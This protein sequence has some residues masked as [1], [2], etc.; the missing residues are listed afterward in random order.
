[1]L[2]QGRVSH[3]GKPCKI[4]RQPVHSGDAIEIRE[5]PDP[6]VA[7]HGLEIVYEDGD[8]LV[9]QK[10]ASLLTVATEHERE[11][12]AYAYLRAY[13]RQEF[14]GRKLFIVHRLDKFV[15]GVMTFAKSEAVKDKL[16]AMF[17]KHSI[18]RRYWA[19]VEGRVAKD[20]GTIQSFLAEDRSR[21]MRSTVAVESG[22]HAITH[23][24]VLRRFPH[25]T[26]LEVSLE[27]GRKNQI[28]AH[29]SEMGHPIVGDKAY[30]STIDPFGRIALHAFRLGFV[31]P[32]KGKPL[33]FE[34][35]P[36]PELRKY[37]PHPL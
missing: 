34:T 10:P 16:Q 37:L 25:Y 18:E 20:T 30:G 1:M 23:Y 4:A 3:N 5:K 33:L 29:L 19:I 27:T 26:T 36:P 12:T 9:V 2:S 15:S 22:K 31:H 24:R 14:P 8:L 35:E 11:Q 17:H 21:R 13:L 32:T 28:R 6:T 7:L